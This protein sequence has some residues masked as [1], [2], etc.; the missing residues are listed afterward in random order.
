MTKRASARSAGSASALTTTSAP[1]PAGSPIVIP[2]VGRTSLMRPSYR[3]TPR[4]ATPLAAG[5]CLRLRCIIMTEPGTRILSMMLDRL[6]GALANSPSLNCRPHHSRQRVDLHQLG[7]LGD[8]DGGRALLTMLSDERHIKLTGHVKPPPRRALDADDDDQPLT[9]ELKAARQAWLDQA[10]LFTKLRI[11]ADEA[12]TYESDTGAYVL[13]IGFP[14]LSLPPGVG[15]GAAR[16]AGR[17][18]LAPVAFIPVALTVAGGATQSVT[19]ACKED[20]I[21][22]VV[23]NAALLAWLERQ[24]GKAPTELFDDEEGTQPWR[25]IAHIVRYVCGSLSIDVPDLFKVDDPPSALELRATPRTDDLDD[26]AVILPSAVIGLFPLANES[27]MRDTQAMLDGDALSGPVESFIKVG[28]SLDHPIVDA[29]APPDEPQTKRPRVFAD[30][31]L[32]AQADPCQA[33]AVTLARQCRGLVMHGPPGTGKSQTITNIIGD[34]LARGQ[35]VLFVCDKR[36]ALDVVS[37][38]LEHLGLASLCALVHDP[39]RDQ[40]DLYKSIREQLENLAE[41]RSDANA[42]RA[43]AKTDEELQKIHSELHAHWRTLMQ[44][45][46]EG[47]AGFHQLMGQWMSIT[48][49]EPVTLPA[50]AAAA[51]TPDMV[52]AHVTDVTTV[53]EHARRV[54][55]PTNP[56]RQCAGVA[57]GD[58][59]AR[60]MADV[61]A[62][63][64][65]CVTAARAADATPG[66][67][68]FDVAPPI[69]EQAAARAAIAPEL[70]KVMSHIPPAP[71]KGW[72]EATPAARLTAKQKLA[73][74][75]PHVTTFLAAPLE[76][77]LAMI[78]REMRLSIADVARHIG[79]LDAYLSIADK[80]YALLC[81]G[82]KK[83][84]GLTLRPFGLSVDAA[85]AERLKTFLQGVRARMVLTALHAEL[86][87]QTPVSPQLDD[88][89]LERCIIDHTAVLDLLTRVDGEAALKSCA[90]AIFEAMAQA[91]A[92][93]VEPLMVGLEA[94]PKRAAALEALFARLRG[95]KLFTVAW[96]DKAWGHVLAGQTI[97]DDVAALAESLD[98]LEGVLRVRD[99]LAALPQTMRDLVKP[100]IT[101]GS[102]VE[103]GLAVLRKAGFAAEIARRLKSDANLQNIDGQRI[104]ASF[105][106]YR[107]LDQHKKTLVRDAVVHRWLSVQKERLLA[108]TG[109]RLNSVGADMK[110]RLT[111]RGR[112]ALRLR[113]VVALGATVEGGDPLMDLRPVWMASPETVA[114]VFGRTPVFDVVVFDEASQCR[115]EEALPVL[116]RAKRV[117]IAGDPKQLPP[118]RFFESAVVASEAEEIEN[119]EQLFESQTGEIED[120]LTAALSLEVQS[121]YLDV[122]YRSSNSD[123]IAFSNDQFYHSRLQP[124]PGHPNNRTR[125]APLTLYTAGGIYKDRTNPAEAQRVVQIVRDLL[126][127]ASPPSIG[128]ACFNLSQR[129]LIVET[130]DA[131]AMEDAQ[132]GRRLAEAR[133]RRGTASFEGLFVKNLENVQGDERDH[134]IISTTYGPDEKGRFYRRFGP[135]GRAGGGRRLNVLVTRARDEV[136]LVTSIP[137]EIYRALPP[138]PPGQAPTGGY[139]LFSYLHYA[140]RLAEL[141]EQ[142]FRIL[143]AARTAEKA[144]VFV[145]S[146]AFPSKFAAATAHHLAGAHNVGSDVHWGNDGFCVDMALH[147]PVRAEDRTLGVLCDLTR[148]EKAEDP[149]EW[150]AFRTMVLESQGWTL[151]R[152]WT[153]QVYRDPTGTMNRIIRAAHQV[154]T[155]Q[156]EEN[157]V[158]RTET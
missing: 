122:H 157:G 112:N 145:R 7:R 80:W 35:R 22:R 23:P 51:V 125:Y 91:E 101:A 89:T 58:F 79:A 44:P 27:L 67:L 76:S 92:P 24:T 74:A 18:I 156:D 33:R 49:D 93:A 73:D 96:L 119:E 149:I 45:G 98:H 41:A 15:A 17:R 50:E 81:L 155:Q 25:E 154:V 111:M 133:Q 132:F 14:L 65:D 12:S 78:A 34:H 47:A 120:L 105:T 114:Q 138:I 56:W 130:L 84:A 71:R 4:L 126:K 38:R 142:Q 42:E 62:A 151:H 29:D 153:P 57:L 55:Y 48:P 109:S 131:A 144:Q 152:V 82:A 95:T 72:A 36:T 113:Q 143:E 64:S 146:S 102:R 141:Y 5:S 85:S 11:V 128:I 39:R 90:K 137:A 110:R 6:F 127:R 60:P 83:A 66:G 115:L 19:L 108:S 150:E 100:L 124:I 99:G 103:P 158:I 63:M 13:N 3:R 94:S 134:M 21:D 40:N 68:P 123:L 2:I 87:H 69:G 30:E 147:H 106:R 75:Q 118:T 52:E 88:A 97:G 32:V 53:L 31:R 140:E 9:E 28:V 59:L 139:L 70:R 104:E 116:T 46:H 107:Q 43:L 26:A 61:R 129:D 20:E 10:G 37:N 54:G 117:V 16:S 136:H 121:C 135:L 86:T 8:V 1:I 77:E 148:F